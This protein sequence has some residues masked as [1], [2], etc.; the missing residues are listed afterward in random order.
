MT[1]YK[2]KYSAM[3]RTELI[4][5]VPDM[6]SEM[7]TKL[8]R[9]MSCYW[10][11]LLSQC[12]TVYLPGI[13]SQVWT[14]VIRTPSHLYEMLLPRLLAAAERAWYRPAWEGLAAGKEREAQRRKGWTQFAN[15][16]GYKELGRLE[17]MFYYGYLPVPGARCVEL[18][19]S[20][21]VWEISDH[22]LV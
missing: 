4:T 17:D 18:N 2:Q 16:L 14:E 7:W 22:P 21:M 19:L 8:I 20:F 1:V 15:T 5:C 10:C 3:E 11:A 6:Q 12:Y 9:H 13:Q